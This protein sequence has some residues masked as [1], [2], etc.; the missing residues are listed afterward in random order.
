MVAHPVKS[1]LK[2]LFS[3]LYACTHKKKNIH[4]HIIQ[5]LCNQPEE[6]RKIDVNIKNKT[7]IG[8]RGEAIVCQ[9][10]RGQ[11]HHE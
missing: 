10:W 4:L 9:E 6:R 1:V 11:Y 7:A 2:N 8:G 5:G 3:V